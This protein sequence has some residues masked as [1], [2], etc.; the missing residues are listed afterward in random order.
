[1]DDPRQEGTSFKPLTV[2]S[3][4]SDPLTPD[5]VLLTAY[6]AERA[7]LLLGCYRR[8]DAADPDTYVAAITAVLARYPQDVIRAVTHPTSGLPIQKDFLP[9]VR[10]VYLACE[11]IQH[12]RREAKARQ[13]RIQKQLEERAEF[14]AP[15]KRG[16]TASE[17]LTNADVPRPPPITSESEAAS[18]IFGLYAV[19]R[20]RPLV[21]NG[22]VIFAGEITPQLLAF[23][24]A[25]READWLW[26]E[27]RQQTAAWSSFLA[28]HIAGGRPRLLTT[29][30]VGADARMGFLAPWPWPPRK[31]G[32][33]GN[34]GEAA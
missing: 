10:E 14:E 2:S 22:R 34:A 15:K 33:I 4:V 12:P 7:R 19:A 26:I 5:P 16:N 1:M 23:A 3:S 13:K 21:S 27:D 18:A 24:R 32:T 20:C 31:D 25:P 17:D 8:A 6:A 30:G 28:V 9:N 11:A 29:R